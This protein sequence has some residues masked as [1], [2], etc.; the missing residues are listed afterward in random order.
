[1]IM[2]KQQNHS[3]ALVMIVPKF[4][5]PAPLFRE[6]GITHIKETATQS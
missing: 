3:M 4:T 5:H 6:C 2:V 1:M